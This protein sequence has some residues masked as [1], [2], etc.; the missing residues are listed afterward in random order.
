MESPG[1]ITSR[2]M[3]QTLEDNNSMTEINIQRIKSF[4]TKTRLESGEAIRRTKSLSS[5]CL[6][7]I[8]ELVRVA[9]GTFDDETGSFPSRTSSNESI[10]GATFPLDKSSDNATSQENSDSSSWSKT[11]IEPSLPICLKFE[12]VKYKVPTKNMKSSGSEKYILES[13]TIT[14]NDQPYTRSLKRRIGFVM[15]DDVAF[16]HL[17]VKET[18]TYAAL[19]HLPSTL[20]LQQKKGRAMDVLNE[21]GLERIRVYI[22]TE[23]V[24][25]PSLLFLDEPTSGLDSTTALWI[26]QMLQD[27]AKSGKTVVT[28]IHQPSS[29]L[30]SMFDKL[31]LLGKSSSLY[32]GKASEAMMYVLFNWV[33]STHA[34]NPAEFLIDLANGNLNDKSVPLELEDITSPGEDKGPSAVLVDE[35]FF[36]LF[37]SIFIF[38]QERAMLVKERSVGMY[39]LSAYFVARNIIDL[40][41]DLTLPIVIVAAQGLGLAIGAACKDLKKATILASVIV[42]TFMLAGGFFEEVPPFM[43][44]ARYVSFTYHT[45]RLLLRIQYGCSGSDPKSSSCKSPFRGLKLDRPGIE[46]SAIIAM[47]I[48]YRLLAYI[49]LGRMKLRTMT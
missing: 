35:G 48:G 49:I 44:W 20:T 23:I 14:Y 47:I 1:S 38:P 15:Q 25:N 22:G 40:P 26:V 24:L 30:F 31:I 42:T 10:L 8:N 19:L 28:T 41:L 6:I 46:I 45:Y 34:M 16:P 17:T 3:V 27:I 9:S 4:E 32:F 21:L 36:P 12:D 5:K 29:R 11:Q 43:S 13:G 37:T 18:L 33:F 39:K 2:K 7:N